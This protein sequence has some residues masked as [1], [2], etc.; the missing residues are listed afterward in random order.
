M[1]LPVLLK[2]L[3]LH[4]GGGARAGIFPNAQLEAPSYGWRLA[5][6]GSIWDVGD[7]GISVSVVISWV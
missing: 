4:G 2:K 7:F 5:F 6:R 3:L 1:D